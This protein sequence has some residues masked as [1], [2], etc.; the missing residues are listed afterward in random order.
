MSATSQTASEALVWAIDA[1]STLFAWDATSLAQLWSSK[2]NKGDAAGCSNASFVKF[3][4]PTVLNDMGY[5]GCSD[6]L[7][8]YGLKTPAATDSRQVSIFSGPA[9]PAPSGR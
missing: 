1:N 7:V 6:Q 4:T 3:A 8:G 2:D 9:A 5:M